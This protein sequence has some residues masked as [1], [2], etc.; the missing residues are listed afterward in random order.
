MKSLPAYF[1]HF[2]FSLFHFLHLHIFPQCLVPVPVSSQDLASG[3]TRKG[4]QREP[5]R[6]FIGFYGFHFPFLLVLRLPPTSPR[7]P[8]PTPTPMPCQEQLSTTLT[9][10]EAEAEAEAGQASPSLH[11]PGRDA[12][13]GR[14]HPLWGRRVASRTS[15]NPFGIRHSAFSTPRRPPVAVPF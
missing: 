15:F 2:P 10:V 9:V 3:R 6:N 11:L 14:R 13:A 8:S 5:K 12:A 7:T 4:A 1:L